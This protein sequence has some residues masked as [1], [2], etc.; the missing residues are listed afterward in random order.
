MSTDKTNDRDAS[1][2]QLFATEQLK[3]RRLRD[4][5]E[6]I[7]P[8]GS[9]D[10]ELSLQNIFIDKG[11]AAEK[12]S[13][14]NP[15]IVEAATAASDASAGG[16]AGTET[17]GAETP[18]TKTTLPGNDTAM[19]QPADQPDAA[20]NASHA[21][22]G[23][24]LVLTASDVLPALGYD[25]NSGVTLTSLSVDLEYGALV[26][27]DD[28]T[29]TLYTN[30]EHTGGQLVLHAQLD[31]GGDVKS[32]EGSIELPAD[33]L[34]AGAPAHEEA[35]AGAPQDA[36]LETTTNGIPQGVD[37]PATEAAADAPD[38]PVENRRPTVENIDLGTTREDT[39]ITFTSEDLLRGA[40]DLDGDALTIT[41]VNVDPNFG[42]IT[43]NGDG[44][45]TFNPSE[46]YHGE[47]VALTFTASDGLHLVE[48]NASLNVLA[49]N[50]APEAGIVDLGFIAEDTSITFKADQLLVGA[51]DIDGDDLKVTSVSVDEK[52]GSISDNGDG[53][54]T[55]KP[56]VNFNGDDVPLSFTVSDGVAEVQSTAFVDVA[57]V[58]DG[59]V[60][61]KVDLG[62][63]KEDTSI[64]FKADQLLAG[65]SDIDGD[66]LKGAASP[67]T[68][69][70]IYQ[71]EQGRQFYVQTE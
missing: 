67:W 19:Q 70:W 31:D 33:S 27:N 26:T 14:G 53:T 56:A 23:S 15:A 44:S 60:A 5:N 34:A 18:E 9:G 48:S 40:V 63:I 24:A 7:A 39:A 28:G 1:T 30:P 8:G 45:F 16:S 29:W 21:Q 6:N 17:Q 37:D 20:G 66:D 12:E 52:L 32:A 64:T 22:S 69:V 35:L 61:E 36:V 46:N 10:E 25:S 58:N 51:S 42:S 47:Y 49:V 55:F 50:D 68:E 65:A 59:P 62:A 3:E 71:R 38:S 57:A 11:E 41:Q 4:E 2:E 43:A 54:Y 13:S